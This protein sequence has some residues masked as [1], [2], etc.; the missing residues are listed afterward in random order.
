MV[1]YTVPWVPWSQPMMMLSPQVMGLGVVQP[2]AQLTAPSADDDDNDGDDDCSSSEG[3]TPTGGRDGDSRLPS[4][5]G[6]SG[7]SALGQRKSH[8]SQ[9]FPPDVV[10]TSSGSPQLSPHNMFSP[11]DSLDQ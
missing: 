5:G 9:Q 2:S 8:I 1:Q 3:G 6:R 10:R 4:S 11:L 7:G